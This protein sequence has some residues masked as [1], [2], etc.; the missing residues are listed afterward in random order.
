MV[1]WSDLLQRFLVDCE[2]QLT[3]SILKRVR[4]HVNCYFGF[5]RKK[6]LAGSRGRIHIDCR[7]HARSKARAKKVFFRKSYIFW[8]FFANIRTNSGKNLEIRCLIGSVLNKYAAFL[9]G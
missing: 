3:D 6:N 5:F 7:T 9:A 1:K 2:L 4:G 8:R